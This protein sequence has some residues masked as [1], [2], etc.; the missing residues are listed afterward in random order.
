MLW[1]I[2]LNY[3]FYFLFSIRATVSRLASTPTI[4]YPSFQQQW[5]CCCPTFFGVSCWWINH[6]R[7]CECCWWINH[8]RQCE[9]CWWINHGR[10]CESCWWINHGR[11]FYYY[12]IILLF[13]FFYSFIGFLRNRSVSIIF[14]LPTIW[15]KFHRM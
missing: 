13:S 1:L 12:S 7:Q 15:C 5:S 3:I 14:W 11:Q 6:R 9:C 8:G 4:W 10:Q 2:L